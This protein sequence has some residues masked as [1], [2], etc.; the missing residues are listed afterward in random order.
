MTTI[1]C[2]YM[3]VRNNSAPRANGPETST[4]E[5][6]CCHQIACQK[7]H[8]QSHQSNLENLHVWDEN[9]DRVVSALG[10]PAIT[11]LYWSSLCGCCPVRQIASCSACWRGVEKRNVIAKLHSICV[12]VGV[13]C[14]NTCL[15]LLNHVHFAT[16]SSVSFLFRQL[17]YQ[18]WLAT[19]HAPPLHRVNRR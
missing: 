13:V 3:S 18:M 17:F 11:F 8:V 16:V 7:F 5:N 15:V 6:Q 12:R 1:L 19:D 2:I 4:E 10:S 14:L 9:D